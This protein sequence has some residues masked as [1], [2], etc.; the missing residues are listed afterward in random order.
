MRRLRRISKKFKIVTIQDPLELTKH[1]EKNWTKLNYK[2]N[3][4]I[5]QRKRMKQKIK[6]ISINKKN[7]AKSY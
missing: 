1:K 5:N 4:K 7:I 2:Q 3:L 6:G